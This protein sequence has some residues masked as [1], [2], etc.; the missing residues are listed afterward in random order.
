MS[1]HVSIR[2]PLFQSNR[3][4]SQEI[5]IRKC[6]NNL[7]NRN[8]VNAVMV[9]NAAGYINEQPTSYSSIE[10]IL[11]RSFRDYSFFGTNQT[12]YLVSG[13]IWQ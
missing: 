8:M 1:E 7:N 3:T 13:N 12:L 6:N 10:K 9:L 5:K 11:E 4:G 2:F